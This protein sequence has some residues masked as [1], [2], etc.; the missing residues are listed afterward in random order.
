LP[1]FGERHQQI[2]DLDAG[3]QQVLAAGLLLERRRRAM[4]RQ[5]LACLDR[6]LV[7]LR[8]AEQRP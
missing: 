2:N 8:L 3:D 5:I 4:N 1:P 6:S 7:V